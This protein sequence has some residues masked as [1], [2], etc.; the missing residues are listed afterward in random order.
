MLQEHLLLE[1]LLKKLG[2]YKDEDLVLEDLY[3]EKLDVEDL[4]DVLQENVESEEKKEETKEELFSFMPS[5]IYTIAEKKLPN[6]TSIY[7]EPRTVYVLKRNGRPIATLRTREKARR[8]GLNLS[9]AE[10]NARSAA[11]FFKRGTKAL[12]VQAKESTR[13][14]GLLGESLEKDLSR[15]AKSKLLIKL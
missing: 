9:K 10:K 14:Y 12:G 5:G 13:Y 1:D 11:K 8:V 6:P 4:Q 2:N 7:A 3:V 15:R